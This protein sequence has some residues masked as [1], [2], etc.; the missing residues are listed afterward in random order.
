MMLMTL[1]AQLEGV[2]TMMNPQQI[3]MIPA[4][5]MLLK[6][7][8]FCIASYPDKTGKQYCVSNMIIITCR[9][10]DSKDKAKSDEVLIGN[11]NA[12]VSKQV[13]S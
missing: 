11:K 8:P 7:T 10:R 2:R 12:E 6:V 5:F 4:C 1:S 13:C 9:Y 3:M